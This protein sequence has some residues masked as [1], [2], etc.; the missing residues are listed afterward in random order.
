MNAP[1]WLTQRDGLLKESSDGETYFVLLAHKPQFALNVV[2]VG[3]D[4]G[5]SIRQTQSGKR[6]VSAGKFASKD[7]TL[8]AGLEDLR[9]SLGW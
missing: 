7:D 8:K 4:F 2:P 9:A 1:A 5:C 6:V 3:N